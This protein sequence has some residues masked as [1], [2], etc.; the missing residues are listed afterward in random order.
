[1]ISSS[2][3]VEN[4]VGSSGVAEGDEDLG[5]AGDEDLDIYRSLIY[6]LVGGHG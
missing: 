5:V 2:N 3:T 1:M 6:N 4:A